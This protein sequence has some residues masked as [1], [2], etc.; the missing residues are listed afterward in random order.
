MQL[1]RRMRLAVVVNP[2]QHALQVHPVQRV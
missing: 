2:G 1:F